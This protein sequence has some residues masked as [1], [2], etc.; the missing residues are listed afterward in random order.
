MP[1]LPAKANLLSCF[2]QHSETPA[3]DFIA[4]PLHHYA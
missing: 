1:T 3:W 2:C 4:N